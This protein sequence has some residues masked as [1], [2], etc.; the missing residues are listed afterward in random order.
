MLVSHK[1]DRDS[2]PDIVFQGEVIKNVS[3]H[4]HLGVFISSDLKW[5]NRIEYLCERASKKLSMLKS[6]KFTLDRKSLEIIYVS[7]IR[8]S[9]EYV[10]TLWAGGYE[11]DLT[12]SSSLEVK[13]IHSVTGA[14]SG[15]NIANLYRDTGWV[16]LHDR[17]DI[18]SL[19][20]LYKLF[21]GEGS[22]LRDILPPEVGERT[23]YRYP[24]RNT[25]DADIPFTRLDIFKRSFFPHTLSLWNQLDLETQKSH[26]L[27]VFKEG[28]TKK[29]DKLEYFCHSCDRWAG[30]HHARIRIGCSKL[31]SHLYNDLHVIEEKSWQCGHRSEDLFYFFFECPHYVALWNNLFTSVAQHTDCSLQTLLFGDPKLNHK[32]NCDIF[33]VV[34]HFITL[35]KCFDWSTLCGVLLHS[36]PPPSTA[37]PHLPLPHSKQAEPM[38]SEIFCQLS[39]NK[40]CLNQIAIGFV[41]ACPLKIFPF[42]QQAGVSSVCS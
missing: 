1:K 20:L 2:I 3:S 32:Q 35:S 12:K 15:S 40:Y 31:K 7:F 36:T 16:P 18:H 17:Q 28:I 6:L 27:S 22:Y 29:P 26:F 5:N 21:R 4:K 14:T 42:V 38:T 34:Q 19:C 24:L 11:K 41:T 13:A 37:P 10:N 9:L 25:N 23:D 39:R 8:P 33:D 30:I